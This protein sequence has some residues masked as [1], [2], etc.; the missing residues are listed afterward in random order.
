MKYSTYYLQ[1]EAMR[2]PRIMA[3]AMGRMLLQF[4]PPD[5]ANPILRSAAGVLDVAATAGTTHT[6]PPF[7]I[8][9]VPVGNQM[10]R[11]VERVADA[12]PFGELL[13]FR[14]PGAPEQPK[15]LIVAP[16]SGH[17]ATLLRGTVRA[18]LPDHDVFIT[19]WINAR[20]V[21]VAAGAFE[22]DDYVDYL[23]HW[24]QVLGGRSHVLAVCQPAVAAL[25]AAAVMAK[26]KNPAQPRSMTLMAG[27][28]DTR[29]GPTKVNELAN[30]KPITWFEQELI[31]TV[32]WPLKGVG[33][34][35][36]PGYTQLTAFMMMNLQR[37]IDAQIAQI[38]HVACGNETSAAQHRAFYNEYLAVMDLPAEFY[39][40]T[41]HRV[42]Q[43]HE[44]PRGAWMHRG[45]AVELGAIR[46]TYLFVV[47]GELD[48]ICSIGQTAAALDLC[49]G[50]RPSMKRHYLQLGVGHYG[51]FSGRRWTNEIYP[52]LREV[53]AA[54][55]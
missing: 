54:T 5:F 18:A 31:D 23:I 22:L 7:G 24:L 11:V 2:L 21:P 19:D 52:Q 34:R 48:D 4:N 9:S 45:R 49:T 14:K 37:H 44:L 17:Y 40:Q 25:V 13:H 30:S 27:P 20:D 33:R 16:M 15:L 3:D 43:R 38:G 53:I 41:V 12:K 29:L 8:E 42:F 35:V 26:A 32:P 28:I 10:V 39:L 36:Y 6:R 55:S 51:V 50:L 1:T 47:E 46:H